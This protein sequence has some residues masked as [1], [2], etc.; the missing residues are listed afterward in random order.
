MTAATRKKR[1]RKPGITMSFDEVMADL[2]DHGTEQNIKIY[3]RHGASDP[4]FGVSFADIN[5]L[6][7]AIKID[8]E[9]GLKLWDTGNMDAMTLA[10]KLM[11]AERISA[12]QAEEM[13]DGLGYYM[14]A[15]LLVGELICPNDY[16]ESLMDRWIPAEA[17]Y[18]KRA[19]YVILNHFARLKDGFTDDRFRKHLA[20]I[21]QDIHQAPNRARQMMNIV[22]LSIGI[23]PGDLYEEALAAAKR[24]GPVDIDHGDTSCKTYDSAAM[25]ADE[26]YLARA[27]KSLKW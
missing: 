4:M 15:D 2:E 24:I 8:H 13:L 26:S 5:R 1:R 22:V 11:D 7:K 21:E 20:I 17:E 27:R 23:R 16:A 25:L 3:R 10:T 18:T 12:D 9:L 19:G 6:T 14:L